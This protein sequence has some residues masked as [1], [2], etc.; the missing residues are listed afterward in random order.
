MKPSP[1]FIKQREDELEN[2]E[3]SNEGDRRFARAAGSME[4]TND[5]NS[6]YYKEWIMENLG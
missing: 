1:F 6:K 3:D 2:I 5:E 4:D